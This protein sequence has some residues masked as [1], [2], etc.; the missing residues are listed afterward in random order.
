MSFF[1]LQELIQSTEYIMMVWVEVALVKM[2]PINFLRNS[3]T[4]KNPN[5]LN[6]SLEESFEFDYTN[7]T[8]KSMFN[9]LVSD[10]IYRISLKNK[11]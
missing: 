5:S 11:K 6:E 1:Y 9:T 4:I 7:K 3:G 10:L 8:H 2:L